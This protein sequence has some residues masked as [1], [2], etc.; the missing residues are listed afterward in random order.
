MPDV[1]RALHGRAGA[2]RKAARNRILVT[3]DDGIHAPGFDVAG[4]DRAQAFATTSGSWRPEIDQAGVAHSVT[5]RTRLHA[6]G[7]ERRFAVDGHADRLRH[8]GRQGGDRRRK[9]DLVLSGVNRGDNM[10]E[11]VT[12]SGTVAGAMEGTMLGIPSIALSQATGRTGTISPGTRPRSMPR[13]HPKLHRGGRAACSSTS[14]FRLPPRRRRRHGAV[15]PP[16][17]THPAGIA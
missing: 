5:L 8:P 1:L 2:H 10:G 6:Q 12:Y 13:R 17:P 11:D 3:N 7:G 9:P 14:I 16:G 4:A 15:R